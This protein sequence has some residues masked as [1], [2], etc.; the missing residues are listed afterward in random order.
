MCDT[1]NITQGFWIKWRK[2]GLAPTFRSSLST[3]DSSTLADICRMVD[4]ALQ[5]DKGKVFNLARVPEG[6]SPLRYNFLYF[7]VHNGFFY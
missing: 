1:N 3:R 6:A 7:V 4:N 2:V 5:K